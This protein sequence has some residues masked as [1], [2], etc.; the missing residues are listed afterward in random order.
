MNT[1]SEL[2]N[3]I[4]E[5]LL[6]SGWVSFNT[7]VGRYNPMEK[8]EYCNRQAKNTK[9]NIADVN[10]QLRQEIKRLCIQEK[11]FWDMSKH[12]I[13]TMKRWHDSLPGTVVSNIRCI[14]VR[15]PYTSIATTITSDGKFCDHK[16]VKTIYQLE[17]LKFGTEISIVT[18]YEPRPSGTSAICEA[19]EEF[20]GTHSELGLTPRASFD[21]GHLLYLLWHLCRNCRYGS[22]LQSLLRAPGNWIHL[23]EHGSTECSAECVCD[24]CVVQEFKFRIFSLKIADCL[25]Q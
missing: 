15:L 5:I 23:L 22:P 19:I 12:H 1:D 18:P 21:G 10:K 3:K 4:Y 14:Q 24:G 17:L 2:R 9:F 8:F 25:S 20:R 6:S 7:P 16:P 11:S 13:E